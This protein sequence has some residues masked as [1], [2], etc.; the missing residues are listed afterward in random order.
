MPYTRLSAA[1]LLS[2]SLAACQWGDKPADAAAA[3]ANAT[4]AA[5]QPAA[6]PADPKQTLEAA[7]AALRKRV[8][9][10]ERLGS[11]HAVGDLDGDGVDDVVVAYGEGTPDAQMATLKKWAAIM[12]RPGGPQLLPQTD[13]ADDC[14][15]LDKIAGGKLYLQVP[16]ICTAARPKTREYLTYAWNGKTLAKIDSQSADARLRQRLGALADA[17]ARKDKGAILNVFKFPL[18]LQSVPVQGTALGNQAEAN[19]DTIERAMAERHFDD[20]FPAQRLA[21]YALLLGEVRALQPKPDPEGGEIAVGQRRQGEETQW[22]E[23][24]IDWDPDEDRDEDNQELIQARIEISGGIGKDVKA[25]ANTLGEV[26]DRE[27]A[28]RRV[29]EEMRLFLIDGELRMQLPNGAG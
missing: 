23:L 2:L 16:D 3:G 26:L 9:D 22:S 4:P 15:Y 5:A 7:F 8:P 20:L 25:E 28:S 10:F 14:V 19:K 18:P 29:Y 13:T 24:R 27:Q 21:D 1:L 17:F 6:K 11:E 12:S